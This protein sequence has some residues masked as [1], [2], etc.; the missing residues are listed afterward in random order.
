M[1]DSELRGNDLLTIQGLDSNKAEKLNRILKEMLNYFQDAEKESDDIY[2]V[3]FPEILV[4]TNRRKCKHAGKEL[5]SWIVDEGFHIKGSYVFRPIEPNTVVTVFDAVST[6][7]NDL[8]LYVGIPVYDSPGIDKGTGLSS[9]SKK[10][11]YPYAH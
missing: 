7:Q 1:V 3:V 10:F 8:W 9:P 11:D 4:K 2:A 6:G 5:Y